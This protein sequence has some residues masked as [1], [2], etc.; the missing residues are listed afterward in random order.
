MS[1]LGQKPTYALHNGMSA[2]PPIATMKADS[3]KR[4]CSAL[5]LKVDRRSVSYGP[6]ADILRARAL[7]ECGKVVGPLTQLVEQPCILDGDDSLCCEVLEQLDLLIGKWAHLLAVNDDRPNEFAFLEHRDCY[8]GPCTAELC[9]GICE[10]LSY[11]VTINHL[12]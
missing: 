9:S 7:S 10:V 4:S 6:K 8:I 3:R 11:I 12:L 1:A 5:P 2:S